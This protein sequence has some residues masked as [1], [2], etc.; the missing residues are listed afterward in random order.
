MI[1]VSE[2]KQVT[3]LAQ[4]LECVSATSNSGVEWLK[5]V[6]Q[7][8]K[9][10]VQ[11]LEIPTTRDEEWRFTNLAPL[12]DVK[13]QVGNAPELSPFS[14]NLL[15]LP[16]ANESRL[17]FVNGVFSPQFSAIKNL[18]EGIYVGNLL[19]SDSLNKGGI[20]SDKI[21]KYLAKQQGGQEV[22][23]ALNTAALNDVAVVWVSKKCGGRNAHSSVIYFFGR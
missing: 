9:A 8:A 2:K 16:E 17:V 3:Y 19:G 12:L 22:F 20:S 14:V 5:D 6:R 13:F 21:S 15:T 4:L 10:L 1:Q 7:S 23:T 11:E 18:P